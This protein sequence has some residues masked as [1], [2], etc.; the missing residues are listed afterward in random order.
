MQPTRKRLHIQ[1]VSVRDGFQ[2]EPKFV[3]TDEKVELINGLSRTGLAKI[4]VTSF[5]SPKAIPM[6]R[7]AEEVMGR[8]RRVPG[9]EYD[10]SVDAGRLH[11]CWIHRLHF[12]NE[13]DAAARSET[14]RSAAGLT[15]TDEARGSDSCARIRIVPRRILRDVRLESGLRFGRFGRRRCSGADRTGDVGGDSALRRPGR[16]HAHG[17]RFDLNQ[18]GEEQRVN[19][20]RDHER[21][22][23]VRRHQP[24]RSFSE[25][26]IPHASIGAKLL[27]AR[28]SCKCLRQPTAPRDL[29]NWTTD[30]VS[31]LVLREACVAH[32][33][34]GH[35]P[36][37]GV[38]G[39]DGDG[40]RSEI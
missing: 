5:T 39:I 24:R 31:R 14:H 6:L 21:R 9:V 27:P 32:P 10:L 2:I 1:E 38:P 30:Y 19:D 29:C 26:E 15:R 40:L 13:R 25:G 17:F 11:H 7:D 18:H 16:T 28:L 35:R 22:A 4:E 37:R 3:P 36:R 34:V 23:V 20:R 12:S 33:R 8:I